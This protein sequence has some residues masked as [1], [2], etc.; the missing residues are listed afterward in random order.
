VLPAD[1]EPFLPPRLAALITAAAGRLPG[2]LMEIRLRAQRPIQ[3][4]WVGGDGFLRPD[5]RPGFDPA[6]AVHLSPEEFTQV[7]H[8]CTRGS[9]YAWEEEVRAGF[10]TLPGGHRLGLVGRALVE[11]GRIRTIQPITG[12]NLRIARAVL[13]IAMPLLPHLFENRRLVSTLLI[14]PPGTGKT[15]LLRDCCRLLS[16]GQPG[17]YPGHR[18]GVVDERSEIG[19]AVEGVPTHDL[20]PRTD[21]LDA[22]PKAIGLMSMIRSMSPQVVA[23]DELGQQSDAEAVREALH[24]GVAVLATAHGRDLADV[25]RRPALAGLLADGAFRRAVLLAG[26]AEPG[27]PAQLLAATSDGNWRQVALVQ[28]GLWQPVDLTVVEAAESRLDLEE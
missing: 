23:V 11:D 8:L 15:T 27:K 20:G 21:L 5:G 1:L 18:V 17:F 12:L 13:D 3:L 22:A 2:I 7:L 16:M 19:G 24:A 26:E 4:V 9:L 28:E 6:K 10:L 25:A 14:G